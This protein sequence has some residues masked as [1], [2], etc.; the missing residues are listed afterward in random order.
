[1]IAGTSVQRRNMNE[2]ETRSRGHEDV[3]ATLGLNFELVP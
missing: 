3:L 2:N 1:M